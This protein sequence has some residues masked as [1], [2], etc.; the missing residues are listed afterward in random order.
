M[1]DDNH[2]IPI[3]VKITN[4]K[5]ADNSGGYAQLA[6]A[7]TEAPM[8][9]DV[10]YDKNF[11]F[12]ELQNSDF[13]DNDRDYFYLVINKNHIEGNRI[14]FN[15]VKGL[16]KYTFNK[17]NLPFQIKWIGDNLVYK[18]KS[19][20]ETCEAIHDISIMHENDISDLEHHMLIFGQNKIKEDIN[21]TELTSC[22][23]KL[24]SLLNDANEEISKLKSQ[25]GGT[26][27]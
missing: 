23:K 27:V 20:K 16:T 2:F 18:K 3:N 25:I 4:C 12:Q 26:T 22:I 15:S 17:S 6:F 7:L 14:Y 24:E 9:H 13:N 1:L 10:C 11:A 19:V 8:S 5:T 21:I